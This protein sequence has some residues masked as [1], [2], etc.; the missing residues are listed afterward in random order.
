MLGECLT[1]V[2]RLHLPRDVRLRVVVFDND[3]AGSARGVVLA[4]P[5]APDG[6]PIEHVVEPRRGLC[7]VRNRALEEA[8]DDDAD[9]LVFLDDDEQP[10]PDWLEKLWEGFDASQADLAGGPVSIRADTSRRSLLAWFVHLSLVLNVHVRNAFRAFRSARGRQPAIMTGN[11]IV[12]LSFVRAHGLRF[13][14]RFGRTGGEDADFHRRLLGLGGRTRWL[15]HA[16]VVETVPPERSRLGYVF[17]RRFDSGAVRTGT[18]AAQQGRWAAAKRFTPGACG[19]L[20]VGS[21]L[22]AVSPATALVTLPLA[23]GH[24]GRGTGYLAGLFGFRSEHYATTSGD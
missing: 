24:F 3:A 20:F 21:V 22:L 15:E 9:A 5:P 13:D 18:V 4:A 10:M 8:L 2:S 6:R 23:L 7:A 17:R 12:R 14:E 16:R 19:M 11:W 1:A